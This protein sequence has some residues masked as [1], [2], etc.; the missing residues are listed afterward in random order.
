MR[1]NFLKL[2]LVTVFVIAC[3]FA[4]GVAAE[5]PDPADCGLG[6]IN[7]DGDVNTKDAVLLAQY[8][9]GWQGLE[10]PKEENMDLNGD[11]DVNTKDAVLL[12]QKLAGWNVS[13]TPPPEIGENEIEA[14][15][16]FG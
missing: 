7:C 14:D 5:T 8:L 11:R 12:A 2:F 10:I 4:I 3:L 6:D 1:S 16:I 15:G 13:F 9:A